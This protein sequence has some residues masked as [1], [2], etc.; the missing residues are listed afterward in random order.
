MRNQRATG[1]ATMVG[2]AVANQSGA[3]AGA[4]AFAA[5]GPVGV[6]A[7]RQLVA[8]AVLLPIARPDVRR[9]SWPQWW[10]TLLLAVVFAV[11][12]LSLYSAVERIGLGLAVTLEVLGPLSLALLASRTRFD[13]ACAVVAAAGVYVLVLPGPSSDWAGIACG[14][15]AACGWAAYILLNRVIGRRLPGVQ[16]LAVAATVSALGYLPVAVAL[17]VGGRLG[18]ATLG[19]AALAGVLS[20]LPYAADLIALRTV[21]PGFF[22]MFMSVHPVAAALVGMVFLGQMPAGHEWAGIAVVIGV[23][24]AS[25]L[26]RRSDAGGSHTT[27]A[28]AGSRCAG[29]RASSRRGSRT[30]SAPTATAGSPTAAA[31]RSS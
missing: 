19:W 14:L 3:A 9:F 1:I 28:P 25:N 17:L 11:M 31:R 20:A 8:A 18:G 29:S 7:I 26:R 24:A 15:T 5:V 21:P 6:V 22:G 30:L 2:S 27:A 10:P 16:G 4:H 13:L 23:L 12:N